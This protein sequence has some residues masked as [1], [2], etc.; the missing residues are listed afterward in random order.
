MA[1]SKKIIPKTITDQPTRNYLQDLRDD[2][3]AVLRV[4]LSY[5]TFSVTDNEIRTIEAV[6]ALPINSGYT[7]EVLPA[8][9]GKVTIRFFTESAGKKEVRLLL[10]KGS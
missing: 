7:I 6:G 2:L 10:I 1:K 3:E 5:E 8:G 9:V 4:G